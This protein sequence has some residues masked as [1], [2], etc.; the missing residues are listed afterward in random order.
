MDIQTLS[1]NTRLYRKVNL[2]KS[3][4]FAAVYLEINFRK[5]A[6]AAAI[7]LG[8]LL[9]AGCEKEA[10][11][12]TPKQV[13]TQVDSIVAAQTEALREQSDTDLDR[14]RSIEVKPLTDS[15]LRQKGN[16]AR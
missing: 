2:F 1:F 5:T 10:P 3:F 8:S 11:L 16:S 7:L 9:T 13:R 12:L 4:I 15:F 14:R 6:T